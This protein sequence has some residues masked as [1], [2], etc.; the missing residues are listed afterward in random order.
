[1]EGS[2]DLG[3]IVSGDLLLEDVEG[4]EDD[5][6]RGGLRAGENPHV[7]SLGD[8]VGVARVNE[9]DGV[10]IG[11]EDTVVTGGGEGEELDLTLGTVEGG[12]GLGRGDLI[13]NWVVL[14]VEDGDG[15]ISVEG[16]VSLLAVV[17]FPWHGGISC[18]LVPE[19]HILGGIEV[20]LED[21]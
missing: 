16:V 12:D 14:T 11:V 2:A 15:T 19:T 7:L 8:Q 9:G 5:G 10:V 21:R 17:G 18:L 3:L 20:L 1:M 6:L 13:L 4:L